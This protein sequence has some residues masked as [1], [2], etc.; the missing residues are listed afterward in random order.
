MKVGR[1]LYIIAL[2]LEVISIIVIAARLMVLINSTEL[3]EGLDLSLVIIPLILTGIIV[4]LEFYAYSKHTISKGWN[5][6]LLVLGIIAVVN[7]LT[8]GNINLGGV[9]LI[10]GSILIL[11]DP[12]WENNN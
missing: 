9:L 3:Q 4:G 6:F 7:R 10:I 11:N 2:I 12:S 1:I 8:S 5:I